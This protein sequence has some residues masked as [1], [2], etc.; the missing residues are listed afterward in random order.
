MVVCG[1]LR[2]SAVR[3]KEVFITFSSRLTLADWSFGFD[4]SGFREELKGGV[5]FLHSSMVTCRVGIIPGSEI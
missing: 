1:G 3:N 4:Q 5:A 2:D